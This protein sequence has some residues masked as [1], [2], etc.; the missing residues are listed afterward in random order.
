M[1]KSSLGQPTWDTDAIS[2]YVCPSTCHPAR[3]VR[4]DLALSR[5]NNA[6]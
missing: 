5:R 6:Q 2:T 3:Y 1:L 4:D